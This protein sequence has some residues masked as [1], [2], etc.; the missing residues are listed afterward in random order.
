MMSQGQHRTRTV[1]NMQPYNYEPVALLKINKLR[2]LGGNMQKTPGVANERSA[3]LSWIGVNTGR[4]T[5][6]VSKMGGGS[7]E[8]IQEGRAA[9]ANENM[10]LR[11]C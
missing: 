4:G 8:D 1:K 7:I 2:V 3:L 10:V 9:R 6:A 11:A 5:V